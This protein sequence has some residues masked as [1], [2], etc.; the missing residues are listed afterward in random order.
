MPQEEVLDR[1]QVALLP[2][3]ERIIVIEGY[4]RTEKLALKIAELKLLT[5]LN[6]NT[7]VAPMLQYAGGTDQSPINDQEANDYIGEFSQRNDIV[8][9]VFE[10]DHVYCA[11]LQEEWDEENGEG[12]S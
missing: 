6:A 9:Q 2:R 5:I 4:V 10:T 8:K 12:K 1:Q 7:S 11:S 3:D